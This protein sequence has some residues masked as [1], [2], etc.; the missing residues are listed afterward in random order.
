MQARLDSNLDGLGVGGGA[1][2]G[3]A[4]DGGDAATLVRAREKAAF[5]VLDADGAIELQSPEGR[6]LLAQPSL[7]E[8]L[9]ASLRFF[10]STDRPRMTLSSGRFEMHLARLEGASGQ[11]FAVVIV[12][13][14]AKID[15]SALT[16]AQQHVASF[17]IAGATVPEIARHLGRSRETVRTH[18][19][20][21]YRRL[22]VSNRVELARALD[23]RK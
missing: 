20:E 4:Q 12:E 23:V 10:A 18:L 9:L 14:D 5:F 11:R 8:S 17:A 2:E 22:E 3:V 15:P 6:P 21:I 13:S 16:P 19:R 1:P 7:R